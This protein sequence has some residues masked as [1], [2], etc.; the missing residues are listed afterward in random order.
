MM[1]EYFK[2]I[3]VVL[4]CREPRAHDKNLCV[5]HME[6]ARGT[7]HSLHPPS[8]TWESLLSVSK[9]LVKTVQKIQIYSPRQRFLRTSVRVA[10]LKARKKRKFSYEIVVRAKLLTFLV[11]LSQVHPHIRSAV[12]LVAA[13]ENSLRRLVCVFQCMSSNSPRQRVFPCLTMNF[14]SSVFLRGDELHVVLAEVL[15]ALFS[16]TQILTSALSVPGLSDALGLSDIE[17]LSTV[18]ISLPPA[19]CIQNFFFFEYRI[20][21]GYAFHRA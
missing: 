21:L 4:C 19:T 2:V 6:C 7:V 3:Q 18:L 17:N 14:P 13:L 10:L 11:H 15:V 5:C 16:K 9:T 12:H 1:R 20:H 8:C